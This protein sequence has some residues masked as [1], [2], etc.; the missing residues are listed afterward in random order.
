MIVIVAVI[1]IALALVF[2]FTN[3][4]HDSANQVAT[5]I[6]SR[7]LGSDTALVIA[8]AANFVGAYFLGTAV[9]QT[10]GSGIIDPRL[11]RMGGQGPAVI[12]AALTAAIVWNLAT[13][14]FGIPSSSSHAL[15]GGLVGA[16]LAGWGASP[17]HW[18]KVGHII[19][20]MTLSP[21]LGFVITYFFTK[22][23]FISSSWFTPHVNVVFKRLQIAS[24][25]TLGLTHGTND[26]QNTM[27]VI[28]FALIIL[29]LYAPSATGAI[30]VPHWVVLI[31]SIAIALGTA[32]GG[33]RI[34]KKLGAGLYK[35]RPIH[36]FAS[37]VAASAT[38]FTTALLGFPTS[39][40]QVMSSSIM[41]AGAA[42]RPK[43]VRWLVARDMGVAW[44]ITIPVSGALAWVLFFI[45][46]AIMN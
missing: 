4:V 34:I 38:M 9:A 23:T 35:V 26:A 36:A 46:R 32:T 16:F 43:M 6:S 7:A 44:L 10:I 1:V 3:G 39:T 2:D 41:G 37:Q 24:L 12:I 11:L 17:I 33:W 31:C 8:S 27:G 15:I 14:Y 42:F 28:T 20:V 22:L 29:G 19:L 40:T 18:T 5:V 21:V 13:W 30:T 25:V 45:V